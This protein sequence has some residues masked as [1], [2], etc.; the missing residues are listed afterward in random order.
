MSESPADEQDFQKLLESLRN[1]DPSV[2]NVDLSKCWEGMVLGYGGSLGHALSGNTMV[3][4]ITLEVL[5]LLAPIETTID[6]AVPLILFLRNSTSLVQAMLTTSRLVRGT[7]PYDGLEE[8]LLSALAA[9]ASIE[10]LLLDGINL[11]RNSTVQALLTKL[12]TL[13]KLSVDLTSDGSQVGLHRLFDST[14]SA[15]HS[16]TDLHVQGED[17]EIAQFLPQ[18]SVLRNLR[19]LELLVVQQEL[20]T[21]IHYHA[22]AH[23]L[24][25]TSTLNRLLLRYFKFRGDDANEVVLAMSKSPISSL[26]LFKCEFDSVT[27]DSFIKLVQGTGEQSPRAGAIRDLAVA[28]VAFDNRTVGQ[29]LAMC[30]IGSPLKELF[31][32]HQEGDPAPDVGAYFDALAAMPSKISLVKLSLPQLNSRDADSMARFLPLSAS[33]EMLQFSL[34]DNAVNRVQLLNAIRQNGSLHFVIADESGIEDNE[35]KTIMRRN[36][37]FRSFFQHPLM[38]D[39][40]AAKEKQPLVYFPAILKASHNARRTAPNVMLMGLM[41]AAGDAIGPKFG[42]KRQLQ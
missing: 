29:V 40:L 27:T 2:T 35:I 1:N 16:L 10:A 42:A 28:N 25:S 36:A 9:N 17:A 3:S 4:S 33:L 13:K 23:F 31:W 30:L 41:A 5:H 7:F 19:C 32:R 11:W 6:S 14:C 22:L 26:V 37:I 8:S 34:M 24:R 20:T 12:H 38:C 15:N 39:S 18:L 21:T